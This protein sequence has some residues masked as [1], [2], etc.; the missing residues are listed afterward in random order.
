MIRAEATRLSR[1][2]LLL[3]VVSLFAASMAS[4]QRGDVSSRRSKNGEAEEVIDGVKVTVEFGR[5]QVREREVWGGLVP[6]GQ[7][8]RTRGL[9]P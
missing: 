1:P 3:S 7:V 5:P 2:I 4:A 9:L 8:W 6:Y